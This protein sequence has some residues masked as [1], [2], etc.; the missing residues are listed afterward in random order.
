MLVKVKAIQS[1]KSADWYFN[2]SSC[3]MPTELPG[4]RRKSQG[5]ILHW[6]TD[7]TVTKALRKSVRIIWLGMFYLYRYHS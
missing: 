3:G 1:L 5:C 6:D 7:N 4:R 2:W